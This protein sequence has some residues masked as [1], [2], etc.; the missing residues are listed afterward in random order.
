MC[1]NESVIHH[2]H[3]N[4]M[5]HGLDLTWIMADRVKSDSSDIMLHVIPIDFH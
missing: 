5:D 3:R 4:T 2:V 1:Q